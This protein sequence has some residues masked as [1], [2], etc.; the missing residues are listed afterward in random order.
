MMGNE[1]VEIL[2]CMQSSCGLK[3]S[4]YTRQLSVYVCELYNSV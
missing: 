2:I 4:D 1:G 3:C